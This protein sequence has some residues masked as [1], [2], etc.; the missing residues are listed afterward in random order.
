[1]TRIGRH[2]V[3]VNPLQYFATADGW[4]DFT[5]PPPLGEML[6]AVAAAGFD[7]VQPAPPEGQ[8][9]ASYRRALAGAGLTA[10]P[11]YAALGRHSGAAGRRAA[12]DHVRAQAA[13][14]AACGATVVF[15]GLDLDAGNPRLRRPALGREFT[16]ERLARITADVREA[17]GL[18]RAEGTVPALHPHVGTWIETERETDAVLEGAGPA[19]DFGPDLGHLAWAGADLE[20]LLGTHRARVAGV[21]LKDI[22]TDVAARSRDEGLDYRAT[23]ARG[24]WREPGLG[25]LPLAGLIAG[26]GAESDCWIV[27]EVDH[28]PRPPRESLA[29]CGRAV[30]ALDAALAGPV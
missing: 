7:A 16:A 12:L 1:M 29:V 4:F 22:A 6:D 9:A 8:S 18:V 14:A 23:V 2:P 30:R 25:D 26:L 13:T 10:G 21:H 3:A 28:S 5:S 27:V 17:A 11:G 24:L 20:R 19:L 15:L